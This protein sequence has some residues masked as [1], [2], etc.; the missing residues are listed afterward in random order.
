MKKEIPEIIKQVALISAGTSQ[1][2]NL[3][4]LPQKFTSQTEWNFKI[5]FHWHGGKIYNNLLRII[6]PENY[7]K[8][9]KNNEPT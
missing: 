6:K 4:I 9:T 5:P 7:K 8:N 2:L 1:S 3:N